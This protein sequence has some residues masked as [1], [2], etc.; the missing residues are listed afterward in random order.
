MENRFNDYK[1]I[2]ILKK[3]NDSIVYLATKNDTTFKYAVKLIS[4]Q[5]LTEQT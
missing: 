3:D 5:N 4:L 2:K 1:L